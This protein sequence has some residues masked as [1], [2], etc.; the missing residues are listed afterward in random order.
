MKKIKKVVKKAVKKTT[1]AS[2]LD[3][4]IMFEFKNN[5]GV[6]HKGRILSFDKKTGLVE[7][8][9]LVPNVGR[10]AKIKIN[11]TWLKKVRPYQP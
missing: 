6:P 5:L 1:V 4:P 9:Y 10:V 8:E 11:E 7:L 2:N 3:K